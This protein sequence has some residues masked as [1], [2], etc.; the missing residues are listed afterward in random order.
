MSPAATPPEPTPR[1]AL[2]A[3]ER[4]FYRR[5]LPFFV[6]DYRASTDVWTRATPF[7][8]VTFVLQIGFAAT[9]MDDPWWSL[10]GLAFG[11]LLLGLYA[12]RNVRA[13]RSWRALPARVTWPFL[14]AYVVVPALVVLVSNGSLATLAETLV[15]AL[16]LLL[17]TWLATRYAILPLAVWA[18]RYTVRGFYDLYRLATRALPL[19]LLFITFLFINTEVWQVAGTMGASRLWAVI[20][21][22]AG[23]GIAFIVG[24]VPA[25]VRLIEASAGQEEVVA[26]CQGTPM[27]EAARHLT[28]LGEPVPLTPRQ[29]RNI[30]LV[31]TVAQMVQVTLFALVV[32]T[33]FVAFGAIAISI[34]VQESW[35]AGLGEVVTYL[36][37]GSGHG[38]TQS[39]LRVSI[40]LGAFAGFY[41]T[42]YTATDGVYR[43]QFYDRI[44]RDLEQS[45][46][47]R[48]AYV[49]ARQA[50]GA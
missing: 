1:S 44:R 18:V 42:I 20:A 21:V 6:E 40:F 41:V 30:G 7:L 12:W 2:P 19:M 50:G 4:W 48:R 49:A 24:R 13:G 5:G 27:A 36:P 11:A 16:L 22:F 37:L 28:G 23:L 33:F 38:I 39:L 26:A 35:L 9:N 43:E 10:S 17:V 15:A 14:A 34:A 31:M 25:E 32:W 45:L 3:T 29:R 47:V 8:A 46:Y